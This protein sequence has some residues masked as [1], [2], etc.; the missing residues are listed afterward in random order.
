MGPL[1]AGSRVVGQ[2]RTAGVPDDFRYREWFPKLSPYPVPPRSVFW[3]TE[4]GETYEPAVQIY[5]L[6]DVSGHDN[7]YR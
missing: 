6:N 5:S 3:L 1:I 7:Y 4:F 2:Y